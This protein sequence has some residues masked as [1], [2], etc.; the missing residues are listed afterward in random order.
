M[1]I[2][3]R[4]AAQIDSVGLPLF[5]VTLTAL[6]RTDTPVLLMLHW[7]GFRPEERWDGSP[8]QRRDPVAVPGSTLQINE[9]WRTFS[10]LEQ[11]V[12]DTAWQLGA[13]SLE[14]HEHRGCNTAGAAQRE[15]LECRQ[16]FGELPDWSD[17]F[18]EAAPDRLDLM[19]TA[20]KLGYLHWHF[21]PVSGGMWRSADGDDTLRP[22]GG[23]TLPCPVIPAP[24]RGGSH[25][26]TRYRLGRIERVIVLT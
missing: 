4:V 24:L 25:T 26:H 19:H 7:H 18:V 22:D 9:R 20:A 1:N 11:A 3:E 13:W 2:F 8:P 12:L 23:R 16:A 17:A 21:R 14:R 10:E 15:A 6:P 5:G